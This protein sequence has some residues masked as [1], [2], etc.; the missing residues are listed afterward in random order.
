MKIENIIPRTL[1]HFL[2]ESKKSILLLGP[3]QT[4][5][6]TLMASL[7]PDI[8]INL[9]REHTYLEFARNPRELEERLA[10]LSGGVI[11]IDE[12][13]RLPSLLNTIQAIIDEHAGQFRFLLTGSSARKLKRGNANL[14]PGRIH[15]FYL[16]ALT[17]RELDYKMNI[18]EALA[19]G[20]LPGIVTDINEAEKKLT[21]QSYA[22]T[23]LKE[24][25]QSEALTKNIEGF[26]RF[27]YVTAAVATQF[28]D[29]T[30][31][32]SEAGISRQS[33]MRYFDI[34]E[35]TL[36]VKRCMP[37][38]KSHRKRLVQHPR[39]FFFD[40]GVLNGLIGSYD[41]SADRIGMLFEHFIF[42]QLIETAESLNHPIKIS[43]YR[44]EYGVEVDFIVE[45]HHELIAIEAK[46]STQ[47]ST[48]DLRGLKNFREYYGK[49]MRSVVLYL[50][51]HKKIIDDVEILPWMEFFRTVQDFS[52]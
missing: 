17:C 30:K 33:A 22:A 28:L 20:T 16:G 42:N 10:A 41:V 7:S 25:I 23:Y 49:P 3:R 5:K 6:S 14:L 15:A 45:T 35:D 18:R 13:Q 4:G 27:I 47:V 24:E 31:L 11:F 19:F 26:S 9:A 50:G 21:L 32:A 38:A 8:T 29:F 44:T 37:F 36:I 48:S 46:A 2:V 43:S 39:F 40:V 51:L 12:I 52:R 1:R 34:L